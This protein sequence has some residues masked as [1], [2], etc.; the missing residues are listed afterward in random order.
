MIRSQLLIHEGVLRS[1]RVFGRLH[2][3]VPC[4]SLMLLL[5]S[6]EPLHGHLP[7]PSVLCCW[8][9]CRLFRPNRIVTAHWHCFF[10]TK[11]GLNGYFSDLYQWI[12]LRV[13]LSV[14]CGYYF[15]SDFC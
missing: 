9:W 1:I 10:E 6:R 8:F 14:R 2:L 15:T 13:L 7:Y 12:A 4:R 5:A 3:P 11:P